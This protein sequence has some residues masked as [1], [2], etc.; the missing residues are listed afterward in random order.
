MAAAIDDDDYFKDT[1]MSFGDH[2]EEL[3]SRMIK[4]IKGLVFCLVIGFI[5]DGIGD[6][7]GKPWIGV[8]KPMLDFI[9]AP[10]KEQVRDFYDRRMTKAKINLD[11]DRDAGRKE[12]TTSIVQVEIPKSVFLKEFGIKG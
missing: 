4:A 9:Q 7:A 6:W 3:R 2:I 5:L 8:G 12:V 1:R 10:V 11:A